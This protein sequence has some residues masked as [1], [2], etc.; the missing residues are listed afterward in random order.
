MVRVIEYCK[1]NPTKTAQILLFLFHHLLEAY[2]IKELSV[3]LL[4]N[5]FFVQFG[6]SQ[7]IRLVRILSSVVMVR[8]GGG[9]ESLEEFLHKHDPCRG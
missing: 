2:Y 7:K 3:L 4:Y 6:D 8:V 1:R 5:T 9:W